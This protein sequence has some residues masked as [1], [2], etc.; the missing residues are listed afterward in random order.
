V[1]PPR[2]QTPSGAAA[3]AAGGREFS[4]LAG[5]WPGTM[6][7]SSITD[8]FVTYQNVHPL[9]LAPSRQ[10]SKLRSSAEIDMRS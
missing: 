10:M 8:L 3:R 5:D 4:N 9:D 1:R 7:I 2:E 6:H